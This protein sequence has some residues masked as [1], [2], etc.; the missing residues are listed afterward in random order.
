MGMISPL[1]SAAT[2]IGVVDGGKGVLVGGIGVAVN[3]GVLVAWIS[4]SLHAV[5]LSSKVRA[6][7]MD[8][9]N[10]FGI[11]IEC[12]SFPGRPFPL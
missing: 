4:R 8:F 9:L 7:M 5:R 2:G 11:R 12:D 6:T 3:L 1:T 10:V